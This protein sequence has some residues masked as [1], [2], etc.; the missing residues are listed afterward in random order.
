MNKMLTPSLSVRGYIRK[1]FIK[2]L[3]A[4]GYK[5][6]FL[7]NNIFWRSVKPYYHYHVAVRDFSLSEGDAVSFFRQNAE[8]VNAVTSALADEKSKKIY[9]GMVKFRQTRH[10]R[11]FP[12]HTI[13]EEQYFIKELKL[14]KD[15]VF[16][17]CGAFIGDSIDQFLRHCK[18]EYRQI[19]AFEPDSMN[20]EKLKAKYGDNSK[21]TLINAGAYD[22]DMVVSFSAEGHDFSKIIDGRQDGAATSIPVRAIDSLNPEKVSFIKMDIEGAEL[23]ALKG[24]EKTILRDKP[25]LAVCIYHSNDDMIRIAEYI[26][27]LIPEYKLYVR[28]YG[29][30]N[31][32]VLYAVMPY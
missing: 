17:D 15:E 10:R 25:K 23:N 18:G 24:A 13:T 8:R 16:I 28:H 14:G 1:I 29:F 9:L 2:P 31:E 26:C 19:V 4:L 12:F 30:V 7:K 5:Y 22:K 32:T 27:N 21:I 20:F 6:P 11:D 3:L